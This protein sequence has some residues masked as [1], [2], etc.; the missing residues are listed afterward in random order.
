MVLVIP[1]IHY[2]GGIPYYRNGR[3]KVARTHHVS[4]N[5]TLLARAKVRVQT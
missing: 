5:R 1:E 3:L 4:E 2:D